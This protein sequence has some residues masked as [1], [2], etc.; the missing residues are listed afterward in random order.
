MAGGIPQT[1][2]ASL[3]A[4]SDIV[5]VISR[6]VPLQK[7]GREY[8]ACCPFHPEK[9][10]S[11]SVSPQKQVYYCFG[12]GA[13]G[14]VV[15]FLMEYSN[16]EFVEAI[17]TLAQ[18]ANVEVPRASVSPAADRHYK[19][20]LAVLEK[21]AGYY[22]MN[23]ERT[24]VATDYLAQRGIDD[25]A[26]DVFGLGY[27]ASGFDSLKRLF[28]GDYDEKL[29]LEAGLIAKKDDANAY[30]RFRGRLMFP[31]RD[32]QGRTVAFGGRTI[33]PDGKPKY[34]NSPETS[35]FKKNRT[36][37]GAYEIRQYRK[38]DSVIIVEGYMDLISLFSHGVGNAVATLGTA[39]T[40]EHI[41]QL[42]RLCDRLIFCFDG[43][44]A[45]RKAAALAL[46]R[47][48]PIFQEGKMVDF[49]FLPKGEDPDSFV[50]RHGKQGIEKVADDAVSLSTFMFDCL[51]EGLD[52]ALPEA[53]V[54]FAVRARQMLAGIRSSTL[55]DL[56]QEQL[57]KKAG[58]QVKHLSSGAAR[59]QSLPD[60]RAAASRQH[61]QYSAVRVMIALLL[62][63]PSMVRLVDL[64]CEDIRAVELRGT[65]FFADL[66]E[67]IQQSPERMTSQALFEKYR[68]SKYE[69][70]L[71]ELFMMPLPENRE[72][73]FRQSMKRLGRH[74]EEQRFDQLIEK[75]KSG[76]LDEK[77]QSLLQR[78]V[79]SQSKP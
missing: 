22:R 26:A 63:D 28:G 2:I 25:K 19:S 61:S 32:R 56:L 11:F 54:S 33:T 75:S 79:S 59:S 20:L 43:D 68:G 3:L 45:G 24:K 16:A 69:R 44:L 51:R 8:M 65:G 60:I 7:K 5:E 76:Q 23:L 47:T 73:E 1:F 35:L 52:M 71:M 4:G 38:L 36:I 74:L 34:L 42:F 57:A 14:N 13:G 37:Y 49:M 50:R 12:C 53:R 41:R 10:P 6:Y 29:L 21:V 72:E 62:S 70:P 78:Y 67:Y 58:V 27:A 64:P 39:V 48:L 15:K 9:T 31:I 17:E 46:E 30:D 55:R 66:V 40:Q 77:G 18:M